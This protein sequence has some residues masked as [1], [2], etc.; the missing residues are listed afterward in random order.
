MSR[1]C[2][3]LT[4][5][6]CN[7]FSVVPAKALWHLHVCGAVYEDLEASHPDVEGDW[8]RWA[9]RG[10]AGP[11]AELCDDPRRPGDSVG[12]MVVLLELGAA[13][14]GFIDGLERVDL[15]RREH[16][17]G[18]QFFTAIAGLDKL[19]DETCHSGGDRHQFDQ[20]FSAVE[21]TILDAQTLALQRAEE[22]LDDPALLVPETI[23][24]ASAAVATG[25]VVRSNQ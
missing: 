22:L 8:S 5:Q 18:R 9:M 6:P 15:V 4:H 2:G 13:F 12:A 14:Q 1:E 10:V 3:S 17:F 16:K 23:R 20:A 19:D 7:T 24:Q 11:S 25:W 21:L